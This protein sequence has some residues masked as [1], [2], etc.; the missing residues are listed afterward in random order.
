MR[1]LGSG[2]GGYD[3]V[4][5]DQPTDP[6][7]GETWFDTDAPDGGSAFVFTD[8][9]FVELSITQH[10]DLQGVSEGQHRSNTRVETLSGNVVEDHR[11]GETHT[12]AQPPQSHALGGGIHDTA[13]RAE[14]NALVSDAT[15]ESEAGAQARVDDH[16]AVAAAHHAVF[17][18]ADYNPEADTHSRYTDNEARTAVDGSNVSVGFAD[19]AGDADTVDGQEAADLGAAEQYAYVLHGW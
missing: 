7:L 11:T 3:Y 18:P 6:E 12:T 13:T 8:S 10:A 4:Q 19:S 1:R 5:P 16:A 15:L 2:G 14:L 17:E 9:G